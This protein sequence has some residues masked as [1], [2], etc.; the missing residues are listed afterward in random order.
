[1]LIRFVV[2]NFFSFGVSKEF[3][4][5]PYS[6]LKSL[7]WHEYNLGDVSV[8]KMAAL[9][10][11]NGAGKSNLVKA[12]FLFQEMVLGETI[13]FGLRDSHFKFGDSAQRDQ[14]FAIEFVSEGEGFVYGVIL[15]QGIVKQEELYRSGLGKSKDQLVFE[16]TTVEGKTKLQFSPEFEADAKSTPLK[17]ILLEEFIR[18][19]HTV[20]KLLS[21]REN[22]HLRMAKKA[23]DWFEGQLQ[24]ILPV[25][26]PNALI[27]RI[28][29]QSLFKKYAEDLMCSLNIGISSLNTVEKSLDDFFGEDN[30]KDK[31]AIKNS[32]DEKGGMIVMGTQGGDE[33]V[34]VKKEGQYIVK[35]LKIGH[36][37][38]ENK[39]VQFG[40]DEESDGT[41]RLLDFV[42][43]FWMLGRR[44]KVI[45]VDEIERSIH[46]LLIKELVHKFSMDQQS[47]GQLIFTTHES[48]LLDQKMFRQDEIWFAEKSKAGF[49]DLYS[50]SK[51]KEH[52]TIDI[53]RG[54][55]NGRYGAI[56]F[57]GNLTELNWH[58]YDPEEQ[59]V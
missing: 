12:L 26:R 6:R 58:E 14:T 54:Y 47:R 37:T 53:Q 57:L 34:V 59:T 5:L 41:I 20:L 49:T 29:E 22:P 13:P 55:L 10:G 1:M 19:E 17:E 28:S 9:Y 18:P 44:R 35:Q 30:E 27:H 52:K 3:N 8:L 36:T 7:P 4:M 23:F 40:M 39:E 46:P 45:V 2:D 15:E 21:N 43:A 33:C 31:Q 51:F 38:L 56:P 50:L 48:N 32:L 42:P 25:S 16:R 24:V 11:A